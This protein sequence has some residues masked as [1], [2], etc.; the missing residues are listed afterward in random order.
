MD[1]KQ[2]IILTKYGVWIL[3]SPAISAT[4]F[5]MWFVV[6]AILNWGGDFDQLNY[7]P[8]PLNNNS[9]EQL[10]A[11]SSTDFDLET[12]SAIYAPS[13]ERYII[14]EINN[15]TGI[16]KIE[17]IGNKNGTFTSLSSMSPSEI[18]EV[19][20][21]CSTEVLSRLDGN[22]VLNYPFFLMFINKNLVIYYTK[23]CYLAF[24][25]ITL[26]SSFYPISKIIDKQNLFQSD[27][28]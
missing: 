27:D 7:I 8:I 19:Q 18:F 21:A 13:L 14:V 17:S 9:V 6:T 3:A 11:L 2:K 16:I 4:I 5:F 12:G 15:P 1:R 22:Y 20:K 25:L 23:D 28:V 10:K 26:I 24:L